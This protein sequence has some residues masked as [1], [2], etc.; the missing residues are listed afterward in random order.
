MKTTGTTAGGS[1]ASSGGAG[2][3][4]EQVPVEEWDDEESEEEDR[5]KKVPLVWNN[6]FESVKENPA[7]FLE[8]N[9]F[10]SLFFHRRR[11]V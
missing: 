8:R 1:S 5:V 9:G 6:V 4:G 2:I 10:C 3:D 11:A 7:G